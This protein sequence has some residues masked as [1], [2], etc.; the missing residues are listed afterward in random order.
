ML[1][2]IFGIPLMTLEATF[3]TVCGCLLAMTLFVLL[4]SFSVVVIGCCLCGLYCAAKEARNF[5]RKEIEGWN[6]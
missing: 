6:W 3:W 4:L 5:I 2:E 1:T